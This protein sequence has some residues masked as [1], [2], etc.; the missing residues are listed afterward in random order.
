MGTEISGST[1]V[2]KT[3]KFGKLHCCICGKE[4][5]MMG[6]VQLGDM[7]EVCRACAKLAG[8]FFLPQEGTKEMYTEHMKNM[9]TYNRLYEAYF[10]KNRE[11]K[12]FGM[13]D[14]KIYVNKE[15][16][17]I[18]FTK[19]RGGFLMFGGTVYPMVYRLADIEAYDSIHKTMKDSDGKEVEATYM[20]FAFHNAAGVNTIEMKSGGSSDEKLCKYIEKSMGLTGLRGMINR[21]H[22][23]KDAANVE[24]SYDE[25]D[26]VFYK[27]RE[28]LIEKADNAIA[29]VIK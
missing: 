27:G 6:R 11:A 12:K 7:E 29:S 2:K 1:T 5:G 28:V 10:K 13:G 9:D 19:K 26:A 3:K 25:A 20:S 17:L 16:A 15:A 4:V 23:R 22:S 21:F 18:C 24:A 14:G 8:P